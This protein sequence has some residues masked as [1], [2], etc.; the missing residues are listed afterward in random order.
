MSE[1]M[2]AG[3][4]A[5]QVENV[6]SSF[7]ARDTLSHAATR[8]TR[9]FVQDSR[10]CASLLSFGSLRAEADKSKMQMTAA[11]VAQYWRR[12]RWSDLLLARRK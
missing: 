10:A 5:H 1:R 12:S 9:F 8:H 7:L 6:P 2:C 11:A 4:Y 3:K